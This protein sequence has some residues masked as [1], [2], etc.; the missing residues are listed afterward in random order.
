MVASVTSGPKSAVMSAVSR[1]SH[2]VSSIV[3]FANIP[4]SA[5]ERDQGV[6]AAMCP[7]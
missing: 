5:P 4:R 2:V 7:A 3:G 1:S 6:R